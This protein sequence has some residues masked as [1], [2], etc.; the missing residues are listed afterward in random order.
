MAVNF[1]WAIKALY[2]FNVLYDSSGLLK[3][4]KHLEVSSDTSCKVKLLLL[5]DLSVV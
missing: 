5:M 2:L 4:I 3:G 1:N